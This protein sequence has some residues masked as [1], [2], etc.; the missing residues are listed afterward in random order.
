MI[1][2]PNSS[3]SGAFS[4]GKKIECIFIILCST[5]NSQYKSSVLHFF[6]KIRPNQ[7]NVTSPIKGGFKFSKSIRKPLYEPK[8]VPE[9]GAYNPDLSV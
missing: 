3:F 6:K 9:S 8:P 7:Y 4:I 1:H 2:G 5:W